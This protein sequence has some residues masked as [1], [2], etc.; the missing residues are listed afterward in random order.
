MMDFHD[1]N[2]NAVMVTILGCQ[3]TRMSR[4][5]WILYDLNEA[6]SSEPVLLTVFV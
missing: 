5:D 6:H 3:M 1:L 2:F 4:V